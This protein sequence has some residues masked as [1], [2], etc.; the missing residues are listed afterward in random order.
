MESCIAFANS[1]GFESRES[2]ERM[3]SVIE[4]QLNWMRENG[5]LFCDWD[6]DDPEKFDVDILIK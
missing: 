5:N 6:I 2:D 1:K 3:E 4:N